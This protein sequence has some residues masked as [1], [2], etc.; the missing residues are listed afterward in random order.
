MEKK[1]SIHGL[2][3][4]V[5]KTLR[6]MR[7]TVFLMLISFFGVIASE[8]Y[9]QSTRLS[10]KVDGIS[11]EGFLLK[12]EEQSEFR[13]FYTDNIDVEKRVSG[14]FRNKKITEIL[15]DIKE[16]ADI[17][18]EVMGR[19]IILS[20]ANTN[21]LLKSIQQVVS[22]SGTVTDESGEPLPGVTVLIKGTTNGAI[23]DIDGKYKL[24]DVPEK[25]ILQF[26]FIGMKT[27]EVEVGSQTTIDLSMITDA[28]GIE[29]VV[30]I[31]YGTMKKADLTGAVTTVSV[32][33]VEGRSLTNSSQILQ[34][35]VAGVNIIQNSGKPGD[36]AA[37]IRIRGIS[38]IDN[39]N[40]PLVVIDG[41]IG[42]FEDV[43]P[44]DIESMS[45]L[46]DASSAAIYG[47]RASAGVIIITTKTAKQGLTIK[48]NGTYSLQ[49]VTR[50]PEVADS[51][52]VAELRNE[53][54]AAIGNGA[55]FTDEII[56]KY[57]YG[58]DPNYPNTDW[59]DTYFDPAFMQNHYTTV[60]AVH[61][62]YNFTNSVGYVDQNG[63]LMGTVNK[64]LTYRSKIDAKF[65]DDKLRVNLNV[66]GYKT[67]TDELASSSY[68]VMTEITRMQP[69]RII[70][71]GGPDGTG[72]GLYTNDGRYF[73]VQDLG[74]G[75]NKLQKSINAN[76]SAEFE[77]VKNL[78]AR[79]Q[80]GSSIWNQE[81][82]T[83]SPE[84]Y[85]TYSFLQESTTLKESEL[86]KQWY[87]NQ[88]N[89][90]TTTLSYSYNL[91]KHNL[92]AIAGYEWSDY[93][94]NYDRIQV[95][96]L[97]ANSPILGFGDPTSHFSSSEASE[98]SVISQFGRMRYSY[99]S[100]YML[101][102]TIRRDG[103]SRFADGNKWGVFPSV[104]GYWRV[105]KENFFESNNLDLKLRGSWGRLG[106][107]GIGTNYAASDVMSGT[108]YYSLGGTIVPG[109]GTSVLANPNTT[110]ETTEQI[111]IGFDAVIKNNANVSFSY[112][113]KNTYDILARVTIP[114]SLGVTNSPYQNIGDMVNEGVELEVGYFGQSK[115]GDFSYT[116]NGNI[117][118]LRNEVTN[119][120]ILDF[121]SHSEMIRSQVGHPF[122]SYYGYKTDGILQID[123]F[124][125]QEDS[126]P[127]I[128]HED[129]IYT[130][131]E[132]R[133]DPSDIMYQAEPGD[134]NL[135]DL[136]GDGKITPEDKTIIGESVPKILYG[137]SVN[138]SYKNFGLN[139]MGQGV[140][141][142][143]SYM[144]GSLVTP[145][146]NAGGAALT[147]TS[148]ENRWT[149]ENQ[150]NKYTRLY[151]DKQRD[152]IRSDYNLFNSSYFRVKS[153]ELSYNVPKHIIN[154]YGIKNMKV[155]CTGE[156][157]LLFTNFLEGF[158]PER[159][160]TSIYPSSHP[161]IATY[162]LG[163][164]LTL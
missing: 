147:K 113:H 110:W 57:K 55:V 92:Y 59:Y 45:V 27:Q 98:N 88:N 46:K 153:I 114:T 150:S 158:D 40:S 145:F 163:I 161:Q 82:V 104:S 105:T 107:Q 121:V 21:D 138:L 118:Y 13:F 139:I 23:T 63:V 142:V 84:Y 79:M 109:R 148:V 30:A 24:A 60:S 12:I 85:V 106:N 31:G 29:E 73:A 58:I 54:R 50:L 157:L 69:T 36:D 102:F 156:N 7:L 159:T 53:A 127:T 77:P 136:S 164:N 10:L 83:Y 64:K 6:I 25:S 37:T 119:L 56:E 124:T 66:S 116:I 39:N 28:V 115:S 152:A 33:D 75:I 126:N 100:K 162:S 72:D 90:L 32:R 132:D 70:Q 67:D 52:V 4:C 91:S 89:Q 101:L 130:L 3:P 1:R 128:A 8:S 93:S 19:H 18:Y 141:G 137:A 149:L 74:G 48:Y 117:S 135:V 68:S 76:A 14:E 96:H 99:D 51:W 151:E 62:N 16:E 17:K 154:K 108:E 125:W 160:Y 133:A 78:K 65:L 122:A 146:Y 112:F 11:L 61:K 143:K 144:F 120:G 49:N 35:K 155:F 131:K 134:L 86:I 81:R 2:S 103:S 22:I 41:I 71:S 97:S 94:R 20:P 38:S 42:S 123:D 140:A 15:D 44:N 111:D 34:G 43:N 47:S 95:K 87:K 26:S 129:R 5:Q 80:Y 9:S